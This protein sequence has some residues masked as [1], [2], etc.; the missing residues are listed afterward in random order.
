M[1]ISGSED[2]WMDSQDE[3]DDD[4]ES[5]EDFDD[6]EEGFESALVRRP[7]AAEW[8]VLDRERCL[9]LAEQQ[10]KAISEL[11]CCQSEVSAILL[12][13]FRWDREKLTNGAPCLPWHCLHAARWGRC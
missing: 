1:D 7:A 4:D 9:E 3:Y 11:L 6:D 2:D 10:V 8:E 5:Q 13:Y 12:R